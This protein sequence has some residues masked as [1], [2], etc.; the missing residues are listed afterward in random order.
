MPSYE[1]SSFLH[2]YIN[3]IE[4]LKIY[5]GHYFLNAL[6]FG[7]NILQNAEIEA[8]NTPKD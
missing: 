4:H 2:K 7:D 5:L 6:V 8:L 3:Q 1:D